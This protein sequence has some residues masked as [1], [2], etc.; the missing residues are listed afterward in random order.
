MKYKAYYSA[1][2]N[3]NNA[4][5]LKELNLKLGLTTL[6]NRFRIIFLF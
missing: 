2:N 1:K 4:K 6:K 5:E 3:Q